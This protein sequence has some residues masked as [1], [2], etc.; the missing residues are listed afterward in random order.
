MFKVLL[1]CDKCGAVVPYE[2]SCWHYEKG[3]P[4]VTCGLQGCHGTL[5]DTGEILRKTHKMG[6]SEIILDKT[7][8]IR[9][10][11][12][13]ILKVEECISKGR[14][15]KIYGT[16]LD[17]GEPSI[18]KHTGLGYELFAFPQEIEVFP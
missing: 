7:V 15:L 12:N 4:I 14:S 13:T 17:S 1:K 11:T 2:V 16:I 18:A 9:D 5:I 3:D 6:S 8:I 10:G